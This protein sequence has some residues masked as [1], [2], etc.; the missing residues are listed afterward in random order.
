MLR[1]LSRGRGDICLGESGVI[2]LDYWRNNG[3]EA[4]V[5]MS[6]LDLEFPVFSSIIEGKYF[7]HGD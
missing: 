5:Y 1:L 6:W 2:H 4:A 3:L 7:S